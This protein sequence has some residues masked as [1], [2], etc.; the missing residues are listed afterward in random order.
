MDMVERLEWL[1]KEYLSKYDYL[2]VDSK[3]K[4][5]NPFTEMREV[6]TEYAIADGESE[7]DNT[8]LAANYVI[9]DN[10]DAELATVTSGTG[11]CPDGYAGSTF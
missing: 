10:T 8:V 11:I 7:K 5:Q 1:D 4:F 2:E 3:I 9:G 6:K